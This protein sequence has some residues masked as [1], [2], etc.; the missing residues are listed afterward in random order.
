MVAGRA[1]HGL[2][3]RWALLHRLFNVRDSYFPAFEA[4]DKFF[5]DRMMYTSLGSQHPCKYLID[6]WMNEPYALSVLSCPMF[7]E[8]LCL[9]INKPYAKSIMF[10]GVKLEHCVC[11]GGQR[12]W[13][14]IW[15]R[16]QHPYGCFP[17]LPPLSL[18]SH[19][20]TLSRVMLTL[21]WAHF[22]QGA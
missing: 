15:V 7:S 22:P 10:T 1:A 18:P 4:D 12:V 5:G 19:N 16:F 2:F 8:G 11:A 20:E 17:P 21:S 14:V 6:V 13:G 9:S 3:V